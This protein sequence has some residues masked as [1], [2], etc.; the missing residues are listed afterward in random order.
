MEKVMDRKKFIK[1]FYCACALVILSVFVFFTHKFYKEN[2]T[3]LKMKN[4]TFIEKTA[5]YVELPKGRLYIDKR[6]EAYDG[7]YLCNDLDWL[8]NCKLFQ[9]FLWYPNAYCVIT[10]I[11]YIHIDSGPETMAYY[12]KMN[13]DKYIFVW[14]LTW[15][16]IIHELA[17]FADDTHDNIS[18]SEEWREIYQAEWVDNEWLQLY[19]KELLSDEEQ[20][21]LF[22]KE[23]FAEGFAS[24]YVT[25]YCDK[26]YSE[27]EDQQIDKSDIPVPVFKSNPDIDQETYPLTFE[28][29]A[30]F[31]E[32]YSFNDVYNNAV[33]NEATYVYWE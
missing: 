1:I 29:M 25:Y 8:F 18:N 27:Y 21:K 20:Y 30:K 17:H 14:E 6:I 23:S 24:W 7:V 10:S 11:D 15:A 3:Y 5:L 22:L 13:E 32:H 28:Y 33:E 31:Y 2:E 9:D 4:R 12:Q 26:Y 19:K 16:S